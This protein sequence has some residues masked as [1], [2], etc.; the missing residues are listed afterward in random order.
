[1]QGPLFL[2]LDPL[3]LLANNHH[4]SPMSFSTSLEH[5]VPQLKIYTA[6]LIYFP[7]KIK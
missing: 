2:E 7:Q 6:L 3:L 1:M 5:L 4:T